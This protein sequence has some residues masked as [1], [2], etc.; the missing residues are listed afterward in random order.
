MSSIGG[1][2]SGNGGYFIIVRPEGPP[3]EGETL[4]CCHCMKHWKV[5]PGS[6]VHR[7]WCG[8][9]GAPTCG[10]EKC[11]ACVPFMKKVEGKAPW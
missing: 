7:G 3:S 9:C 4:Q 11:Q 10:G 1:K 5:K 6:G 8:N 2:H